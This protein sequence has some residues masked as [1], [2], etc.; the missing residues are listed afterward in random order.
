MAFEEFEEIASRRLAEGEVGM[1]VQEGRWDEIAGHNNQLG[2]IFEG[3][4]R[5]LVFVVPMTA[6]KEMSGQAEARVGIAG[7]TR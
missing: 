1:S 5:L 2:E 6:K 4:F 7:R 3:H